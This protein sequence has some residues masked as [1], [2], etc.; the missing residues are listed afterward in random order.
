MEAANLKVKTR[1]ILETSL[2]LWTNI[3]ITNHTDL[4]ARWKYIFCIYD[5]MLHEVLF[6]QFLLNPAC[7]YSV[8]EEVF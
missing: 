6:K 3:V 2:P 4:V 1:Y 8:D 5:L 7:E